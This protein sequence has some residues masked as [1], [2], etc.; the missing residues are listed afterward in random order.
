MVWFL[1]WNPTGYP[2]GPQLWAGHEIQRHIE[3]CKHGHQ[4][5]L[6]GWMT[7]PGWNSF[8][9]SVTGKLAGKEDIFGYLKLQVASSVCLH[10]SILSRNTLLLKPNDTVLDKKFR[11]TQKFVTMFT[12]ISHQSIS[13]TRW[14]QTTSSHSTSLKSMSILILSISVSDMSP[15]FRFPDYNFVCFCG[16]YMLHHLILLHFETLIPFGKE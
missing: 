8:Q 10:L 7:L 13:I 2:Q 1:S 6:R 12:R 11:H 16:C 14:I 15:I 4:A 9:S 5:L 3:L